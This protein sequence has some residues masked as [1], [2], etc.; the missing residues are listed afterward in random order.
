MSEITE[1]IEE[2]ETTLKEFMQDFDLVFSEDWEITVTHITH[3]DYIQ[4][5]GTF[6]DPK[7]DDASNNWANRGALLESYGKLTELMR[8]LR[9]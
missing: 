3:E 8:R 4:K 6:L 2:L 1:S 5:D 9:I 7:V